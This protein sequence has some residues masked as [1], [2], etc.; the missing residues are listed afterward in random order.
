MINKHIH[1]RDFNGCAVACVA[2]LANV[3]YFVA[4]QAIFPKIEHHHNPYDGPHRLYDEI[5]FVEDTPLFTGMRRLGLKIIS[6]S[7]DNLTPNDIYY[8]LKNDALL[9]MDIGRDG[10]HGCTHCYAWDAKYKKCY[11]PSEY[12]AGYTH[13]TLNHILNVRRYNVIHVIEIVGRK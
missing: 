4:R 10:Y 7:V 3:D 6:H 9:T 12:V 13:F 5:P 8:R 11:D 2:M 1:Q